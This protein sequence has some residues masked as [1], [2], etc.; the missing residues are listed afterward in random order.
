MRSSDYLLNL[1]KFHSWDGG[2][3]WNTG[4]FEASHLGSLLDFLCKHSCRHIIET[5]AGN[6][7][8]T[9]LLSG[10]ERVVSIAPDVALFERIKSYC[11]ANDIDTAHLR[12]ILG[13]SQWELPKLAANAPADVDFALIDGHHGWPHVFVDFCY[14]NHM[15][16]ADGFIMIDDIQLHSVRELLNLLSEQ[17]GYEIA[18]DLG[19]AVVFRKVTANRFLPEWKQQPYIARRSN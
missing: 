10:S 13:Y 1:P 9:F 18:L 11:E 7:T 2:K 12:A 8:I 4:G 15:V 17:P 6:S 5:G 14:L 19:K 16:H 3:T